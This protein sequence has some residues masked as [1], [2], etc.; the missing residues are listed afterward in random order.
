MR[1]VFNGD[2]FVEEPEAA[3]ICAERIVL[4]FEATKANSKRTG[5]SVRERRRCE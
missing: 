5:G 1:S 4:V 3:A 2:H